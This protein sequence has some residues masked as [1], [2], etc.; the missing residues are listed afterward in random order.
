MSQLMDSEII[1]NFLIDGYLAFEIIN[2]RFIQL[3]PC[4]LE[5]AWS[6]EQGPHWKQ[7]INN[8]IIPK[9]KLLYISYYLYE[10]SFLS[11]IYE[12]LIDSNDEKF[13]LNHVNY[14][15]DRLSNNILDYKKILNIDKL[16]LRGI[17]VKKIKEKYE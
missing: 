13:I 3:D 6:S 16:I 2:N 15:I 7:I 5:F 9:D 1:I 12:G 14:V 4:N 11:S 8:K 17:K 10:T